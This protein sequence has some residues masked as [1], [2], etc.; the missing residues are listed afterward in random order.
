MKAITIWQPWAS[1][2]AYGGKQFETRSWA[3]SYRGPM[4]IPPQDKIVMA[5]K[6]AE[7]YCCGVQR[8]FRILCTDERE[9]IIVR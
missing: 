7:Q 1:L 8:P 3:T 5:L 2:L 9:E 6:A 4:D